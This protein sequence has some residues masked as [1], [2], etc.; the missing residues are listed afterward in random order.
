M[1]PQNNC[2]L[3]FEIIG[4][5]EMANIIAFRILY[6]CNSKNYLNLQLQFVLTI[7]PI[8]ELASVTSDSLKYLLSSD[9]AF[10]L[11]THCKNEFL[12]NCR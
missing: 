8:L 4:Y 12:H 7:K 11:A 6:F 2:H 10:R 5:K 9:L 3:K 1:C